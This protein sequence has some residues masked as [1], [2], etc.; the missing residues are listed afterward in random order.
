M[1]TWILCGV[2]VLFYWYAYIHGIKKKDW[3]DVKIA[4]DPE[5]FRRDK[6][7]EMAA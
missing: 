4:K 3:S 5:G 6:A 1:I 7:K 2:E